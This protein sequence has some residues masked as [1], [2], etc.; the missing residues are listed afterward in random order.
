MVCIWLAE[1][2]I[3]VFFVRFRGTANHIGTKCN[4]FDFGH[5]T[6]ISTSLYLSEHF[7][8]SSDSFSSCLMFDSDEI[9]CV[10]RLIMVWVIQ[11][12]NNKYIHQPGA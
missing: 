6:N 1:I 2:D 3:E 4:P 12:D 10:A 7:S 9:C 8:F 11:N 5:T